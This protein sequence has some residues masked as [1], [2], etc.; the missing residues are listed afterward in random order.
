[1]TVSDYFK[2]RRIFDRRRGNRLGKARKG[3]SNSKEPDPPAAAG[4]SPVGCDDN[5]GIPDELEPIAPAIAVVQTDSEGSCTEPRR[6][7]SSVQGIPEGEDTIE[8]G[9]EH[10]RNEVW[11]L[12][13]EGKPSGPMPATAERL[14][15]RISRRVSRRARVTRPSDLVPVQNVD[16]HEGLNE[17]VASMPPPVC[18][19]RPRQPRVPG[20]GEGAPSATPMPPPPHNRAP[21]PHQVLCLVG[22]A[23]E[24]MIAP[25]DVLAVK[26]SG[27]LTEIGTAHGLMGHVLLV[28]APPGPIPRNSEEGESLQAVWPAPDVEEIWRVRTM[29][30]TRSEEGLHE[31]DM[32]LYVERSS[33]QLFVIGELQR[34]GTLVIA[35]HEAVELWQSPA[36]LRAQ[37]RVDL[38][39]RV[40]ADMKAN[41]ASWS[42][43][44]AVRAAI[45]SARLPTGK[46]KDQKQTMDMV[47][48]CWLREPICTSV[49]IIFWQRYLCELGASSSQQEFDLIMRWMPLKA[50][51]GLPGDLLGAMRSSGW[52]AVPQVPRIFRPMVCGPPMVPC[53]VMDPQLQP[54]IRSREV[55]TGGA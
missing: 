24:L 52:V 27:R 23:L 9:S 39:L 50:D 41:E 10:A 5:L 19:P 17:P 46:E 32:L 47:R 18:P 45:S 43:V 7:P 12:P 13:T 28:L 16:D 20:G 14:E 44:T 53:V 38:M 48:A 30:S 3:R 42:S 55:A 15:D 25:G 37:I 4:A 35:D 40:L 31:A 36:E 2:I 6:S 26:G 54:T 8:Y 1:M 21:S 11:S 34:D 49:V 33:G 22:D 29:E 51:R